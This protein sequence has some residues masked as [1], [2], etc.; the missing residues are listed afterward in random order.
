M[1]LEEYLGLRALGGAIF[2]EMVW[3]KQKE[4]NGSKV[5]FLFFFFSP[6][7]WGSN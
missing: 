3:V 2:G 6:L 4:K 5:G 7:F 1:V